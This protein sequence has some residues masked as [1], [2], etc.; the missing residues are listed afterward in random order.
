MSTFFF[1][2]IAGECAQKPAFTITATVIHATN[3]SIF[4]LVGTD[5]VLVAHPAWVD[6]VATDSLLPL[7]GHAAD[8]LE[9]PS[10]TKLTQQS[11]YLLVAVIQ[12]L[13]LGSMT[14]LPFQ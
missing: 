8:E 11:V 3:V 13:H 6:V 12:S 14:T 2:Y 9:P 5:A 4:V 7:F 1:K 10:A